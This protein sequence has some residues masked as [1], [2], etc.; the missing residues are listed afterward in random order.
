MVRRKFRVGN[1][2]QAKHDNAPEK[3]KGRIGVIRK[4]E[5]YLGY[6]I[7]FEDGAGSIEFLQPQH[8]EELIDAGPQLDTQE[9]VRPQYNYFEQRR[10]PRFEVDCFVAVE[11]QN[12]RVVG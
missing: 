1:R 3:F 4:L 9:A 12:Q 5:P 8:I 7:E 10:S 6:G 11:F 2:V